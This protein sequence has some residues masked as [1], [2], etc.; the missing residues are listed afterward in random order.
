M[1]ITNSNVIITLANVVTA[2]VQMHCSRPHQ[3]LTDSLT[4]LVDY[5]ASGMHYEC[6]LQCALL[7][8]VYSFVH[9]FGCRPYF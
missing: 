6:S 9:S 2:K 7:V 1:T 5:Q 8:F 3:P 4:N